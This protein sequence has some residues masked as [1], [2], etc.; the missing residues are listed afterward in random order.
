MTMPDLGK[1]LELAQQFWLLP[2]GMIVI[3]F[4]AR[5]HFNTP[6]YALVSAGLPD[7]SSADLPKTSP[8]ARLRTSAPPIFTTPR[9]R[10]RKSEIKY[11]LGLEVAYLCLTIFPDLIAAI[12]NFQAADKA[13]LTD[14]IGKSFSNRAILGALLC[15]G[16]LSSFPLFREFDAWLLKT[17]HGQASIPDDAE[18]T[19]DQL[20]EVGYKRNCQTMRQIRESAKSP[21]LRLVADGFLTGSLEMKWLNVRCLAESLKDL[22]QDSRYWAFKRKF[23]QEFQDI[24]ASITHLRQTVADQL[25]IQNTVVPSTG[26]TDID[27]WINDNASDEFVRKLKVERDKVIFEID[28]LFYRMCLFTSLVVY[29]TEYNLSKRYRK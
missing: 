22:L 26:L 7:S 23:H 28:A 9:D 17:L 10:Y 2:L 21:H 11:V 8:L 5:Y 13:F 18:Q 3:Y 12:P 19:A 14:F 15:T 25:A 6:D 27:E 20:F 4:F 29:A 1:T 24:T 16:F